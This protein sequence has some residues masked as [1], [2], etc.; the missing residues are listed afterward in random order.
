MAF[1]IETVQLLRRILSWDLQCR[2]SN[3]SL[4]WVDNF[5]YSAVIASVG[6]IYFDLS[7]FTLFSL[8]GVFMNVIYRYVT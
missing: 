2:A 7:Y 4:I 1:L 6:F 8:E 5:K 3:A